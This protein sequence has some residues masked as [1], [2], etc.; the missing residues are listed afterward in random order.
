[1]AVLNYRGCVRRGRACEFDVFICKLIRFPVAGPPPSSAPPRNPWIT[2]VK[3]PC[4]V[5]RMTYVEYK[6]RNVLPNNFQPI[7][8]SNRRHRVSLIAP[9]Y[10]RSFQEAIP[11]TVSSEDQRESLEREEIGRL[12]S[13]QLA[14]GRETSGIG[15][16]RC[17]CVG[18]GARPPRER[19]I[20]RGNVKLIGGHYQKN[21][22]AVKFTLRPRSKHLRSVKTEP[23]GRAVVGGGA[24][25]GAAAWVAS[26]E[27]GEPKSCVLRRTETGTRRNGTTKNA[28]STPEKITK[29]NKQKQNETNKKGWDGG[30]G[31]K[32]VG[33]RVENINA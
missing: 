5:M 30:T 14:K 11:T 33:K 26:A 23:R 27:E 17:S 12:S 24:R 10:P 16:P 32:R 18:N 3:F 13:Y 6:M 28:K 4:S 1:M 31:K 19:T 2:P 29:R 8:R 22:R 21:Y 20:V 15:T 9:R 7:I 25:R